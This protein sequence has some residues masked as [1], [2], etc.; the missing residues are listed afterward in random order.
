[1]KRTIR[2][3][4]VQSA[5]TSASGWSSRAMR[6]RSLPLAATLGVVI[7][8]GCARSD[9]AGG[10]GGSDPNVL[11]VAF[12]TTSEDELERR[13]QAYAGLGD[14]LSTRLGIKVQIVRGASFSA[15]VEAMRAGK[16]D[17]MNASP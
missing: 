14:Y 15:A 6:V 2:H 13:T 11:R 5:A 3:G 9:G 8:A 10:R 7:A 16:V 17:V 12:T 1:M 4:A